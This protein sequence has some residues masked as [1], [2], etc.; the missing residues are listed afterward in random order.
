VIQRLLHGGDG[1]K[2]A[3]AIVKVDVGGGDFAAGGS[4]EE[5]V[6][7]QE[8]TSK[9]WTGVTLTAWRQPRRPREP[10]TVAGESRAED[11]PTEAGER[12]MTSPVRAAAEGGGGGTAR[13][14]GEETAGAGIEA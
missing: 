7:G 2:L 6:I 13:S 10:A 14:E 3:L 9:T 4:G 8:G 5:Q 12:G 1:G 11:R